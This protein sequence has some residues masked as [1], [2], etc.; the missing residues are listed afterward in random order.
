MQEDFDE[1]FDVLWQ[2]FFDTHVNGVESF[3]YIL[4]RTLMR[5]RELLGFTRECINVAVNRTHEKVTQDDILKAEDSFS[6]DLLVDVNLELQDVSSDY[7]DIP[8]AF[9]G[10][11][12]VLSK[13]EVEERLLDIKIP[14]DKVDNVISLLLWFGFLGIYVNAD[15]ERYSYQFQHDVKIMIAGIKQ[16]SYCIHPGFRVALG[17]SE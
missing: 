4:E 7:I 9:I 3:S 17:C 16:F 6:E 5:P 2:Y 1:P 15:D 8:Y 13:N 12:V 11:K 10:S 14:P